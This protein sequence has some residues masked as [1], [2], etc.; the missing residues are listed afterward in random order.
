[1]NLNKIIIDKINMFKN[2]DK[3][4]LIMPLL[5]SQESGLH[6]NILFF[7]KKTDE[8]ERFDPNGI[9]AVA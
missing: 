8:L 5:L 3:R 4:Y 1:M 7:D 6:A 9:Q 2:S